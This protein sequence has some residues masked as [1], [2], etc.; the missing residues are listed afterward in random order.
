MT[1]IDTADIVAYAG[2]VDTVALKPVPAANPNNPRGAFTFEWRAWEN[3]DNTEKKPA[4]DNP[5]VT[6]S[7][8]QDEV[9]GRHF[10]RGDNAYDSAKRPEYI[11]FVFGRTHLVAEDIWGGVKE[12][13][14]DVT[15]NPL[16]LT[17]PPF[18]LHTLTV[19][20]T[21]VRYIEVRRNAFSKDPA[22]QDIG[23]EEEFR[24]IQERV[25]TFVT[26]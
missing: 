17:I 15:T 3:A 20:K 18:V 13:D 24:E 26:S 2:T 1:Y 16:Q 11:L 9:Y 6:V 19:D 7:W 25:R 21:G 10:H 12:I 23:Y 8:R 14:I 22:K 5:Q 4:F